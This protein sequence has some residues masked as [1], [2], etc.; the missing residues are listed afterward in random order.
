MERKLAL[1][2]IES[3]LRGIQN[4]LKHLE[5]HGET[6]WHCQYEDVVPTTTELIERYADIVLAYM[7][8]L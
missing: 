3:Y 7:R 8:A 2:N 6:E 4:K 5:E 1:M